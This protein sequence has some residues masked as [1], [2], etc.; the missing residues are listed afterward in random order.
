VTRAE[1]QTAT[2]LDLDPKDVDRILAS[3]VSES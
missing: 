2:E 3:A 1:K